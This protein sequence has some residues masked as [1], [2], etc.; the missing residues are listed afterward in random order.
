MKSSTNRPARRTGPRTARFTRA[1]AETMKWLDQ[2]VGRQRRPTAR[3]DGARRDV[4]EVGAQPRRAGR[5]RRRCPARCRRARRSCPARRRCGAGAA[6]GARRACSTAGSPRTAGPGRVAGRADR[7]P[8]PAAIR[9]RAR[10]A[11]RRRAPARRRTRRLPSATGCSSGGGGGSGGSARAAAPAGGRCAAREQRLRLV[12]RQARALVLHQRAD[13]QLEHLG[14]RRPIDLV[15]AAGQLDVAHQEALRARREVEARAAGVGHVDPD[16]HGRIAGGGADGER[17]TRGRRVDAQPADAPA[18][19]ARHGQPADVLQI[20][21][22]A[23]DGHVDG[24][25]GERR[26][27]LSATA[28][29]AR[30]ADASASAATSATPALR[31][32]V[33]GSRGAA[34]RAGRRGCRRAR[35]AGAARSRVPRRRRRATRTPV[36]C[37]TAPRPP[38]D[39]ARSARR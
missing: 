38:A 39:R 29:R 12:A 3:A 30:A 17:P 37:R 1:A 26:A 2:R 22:R 6:A 33:E 7:A 18:Q 23:D 27:R 11:R 19:R 31:I 15:E 5:R 24:V 8:A 14:Q 35:R 20:V 9:A 32:T 13:R 36:P 25:G 21:R 28:A 10:S 4:N 34:A 16:A